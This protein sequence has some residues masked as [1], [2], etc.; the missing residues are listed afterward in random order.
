M[1]Q[2]ICQQSVHVSLLLQAAA[3]C[4][5]ALEFVVLAGNHSVYAAQQL[6]KEHDCG[7]F[8][9]HDLRYRRTTV[10]MNSDLT[11]RMRM[12]LAGSSSTCY[13][14]SRSLRRKVF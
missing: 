2:I 4:G 9:E 7:G 3:A 12:I 8:S 6:L 11:P 1:Y 13:S 10:L 14:S 5:A